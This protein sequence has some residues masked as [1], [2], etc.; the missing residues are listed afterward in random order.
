VFSATTLLIYAVHS[1]ITTTASML[2]AGSPFAV[3]VVSH[4]VIVAL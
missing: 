4:Y 2:T 1:Y 3:V